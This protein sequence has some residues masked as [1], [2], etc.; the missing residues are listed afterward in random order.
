MSTSRFESAEAAEQ[1]AEAPRNYARDD[2]RAWNIESVELY[3]QVAAAQ[4]T[5]VAP[6]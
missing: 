1:A 4:D 3:E 6:G 5:E 2:A